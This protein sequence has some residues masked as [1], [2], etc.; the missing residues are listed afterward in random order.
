MGNILQDQGKVDK[1]IEAYDKAIFLKPN[2]AQVHQN[3]SYVF[4]NSGRFKEGLDEYEWR[5]KT[6]KGLLRQRHF[7]QPC[8]DSEISLKGKK[9][10]LYYEQR[11]E[12]Y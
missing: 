4:L 5:L 1:A 3:L 8:W 11:L 2:H 6:K 7:N 9:I 12:H 10:L